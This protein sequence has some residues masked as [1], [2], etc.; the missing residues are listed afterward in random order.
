MQTSVTRIRL[1]A[2]AEK[3][4]VKLTSIF[5][6]VITV[7]AGAITLLSFQD[8]IDFG[9]T[10]L[11]GTDAE[12]A[13]GISDGWIVAALAAAIVLLTGGVIFRPRPAPVLLPLIALAALGVLLIAGFDTITNWQASGFHP[14]NPGILV[15][16]NG[17]PTVAPYAIAALAVLIAVL[18]AVVRAIEMRENPH[19]LGEL[20]EHEAP[21]QEASSGD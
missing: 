11:R 10:E 19:L 6:A 4:S 8:W 2:D 5:L 1:A 13:T 7:A 17:D 14:D 16:S 3:L 21:A 18:S 15:Q 20:V 9:I 12:A